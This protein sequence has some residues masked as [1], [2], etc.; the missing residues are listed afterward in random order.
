MPAS[1]AP[2]GLGSSKSPSSKG[3][4]GPKTPHEHKPPLKGME[5]FIRARCYRLSWEYSGLSDFL[6]APS[7][8][9]YFFKGLLTMGPYFEGGFQWYHNGFISIPNQGPI[10][11]D[12]RIYIGIRIPLV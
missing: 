9:S 2:G 1:A 8:G 3:T 5:G 12:H 6:W 7:I 11:G 10:L 4:Q